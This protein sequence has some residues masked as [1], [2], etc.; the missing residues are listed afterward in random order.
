[1]SLSESRNYQIVKFLKDNGP[2]RFSEIWKHL[3]REKMGYAKTKA[4]AKKLKT[5]VGRHKIKRKEKSTTRSFPLY[6]V[7]K[8]QDLNFAIAGEN[9]GLTELSNPFFWN[10][11][12]VKLNSKDSYESKFIKITVTKF[13][14]YVLASLVENLVYWIKTNGRKN[15]LR[16]IWLKHALDLSK[17]QKSIFDGFLYHLTEDS[18]LEETIQK[19]KKV[20]MKR[21]NK[22]K[23]SMDQLYPKSYRKLIHGYE[24]LWEQDLTLP[25]RLRADPSYSKHIPK[26][27]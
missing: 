13:G 20:I 2:S 16:K 11:G 7:V 26:D 15:D 5:L 17:Y 1:M 14:F 22:V 27:N 8:N 3:E 4:L 24:V 21:I 12:D 19:N 10:K 18:I 25:D 6:S 9:F 23:K